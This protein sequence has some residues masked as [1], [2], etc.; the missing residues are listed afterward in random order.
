MATI[1][2]TQLCGS[3][4]S[5]RL[6]VIDNDP[7]TRQH[8]TSVLLRTGASVECADAEH[9]A[10]IAVHR[11]YAAI[12]LAA[13]VP[14]P[15]T[16]QLIENLK[17]L[18][19]GTRFVLLGESE[20]TAQLLE[21]E[22]MLCGIV[23]SA[24]ARRDELLEMSA[25][26]FDRSQEQR[27][28]LPTT[29]PTA[30]HEGTVLVLTADAGYAL[31]IQR[32]LEELGYQGHSFNA[33]RDL[34]RAVELGDEGQFALAIVDTGDN[35]LEALDGVRQLSA[36]D[37]R[38]SVVMLYER[39][40]E[41]SEQAL[42][43]GVLE[44]I[45]RSALQAELATAI[46][47]AK[48]RNVAHQALRFRATHDA[49]THL[50]NRDHFVDV[51]K[52][53]LARSQR[54]SAHCGLIYI[55]LD[56]FKPINDRYGHAAGDLVLKTVAANLQKAL[57][58]SQ[59]AA[60]LGGDE[61][62][63]LIEDVHDT[64]VVRAVAQRVLGQLAEPIT[65]PNGEVVHVHGSLGVALSSVPET[66]PSDL[67]EAADTAMFRA[68]DAGGDQYCLA[69][70]SVAMEVE[71]R[72]RLRS[73]LRGAQPSSDLYLMYQPQFDVTNRVIVSFEALLRWRRNDS[74]NVSPATFIPLLEQMGRSVEIGAWVLREATVSAALWGKRHRRPVRMAVNVSPSQLEQPQFAAYVYEVLRAAGLSPRQLEIEVSEATLARNSARIYGT[75]MELSELGA[76]IVLDDFG[77]NYAAL[78]HL[79][80]YPITALKIDRP[81]IQSLHK[82]SSSRAMVAMII[83]LAHQLDI[84]AAAVGVEQL[85]HARYLRERKCDIY[86]GYLFGKPH[87][88]CDTRREAVGELKVPRALREN[89]LTLP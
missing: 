3:E 30:T 27:R 1:Q 85:A 17:H 65:L 6:L 8:V 77:T 43:C 54:Q 9:A 82:D 70:E 28:R 45:D 21:R 84:R 61:F 10:I 66:T 2:H 42:A 67:M 32:Q 55:D 79:K 47:R 26:A 22:G 14:R 46:R 73:E 18:E 60:R 76:S 23:S 62:V 64:S 16:Q 78:N 19:Y 69:A 49:L 59:S 80:R 11:E 71:S 31:R 24:R 51:L 57:R 87:F 83:D 89:P 44:L 53:A 7:V 13:S 52:R 50:Y 25:F 48:L 35:P 86:Q 37:P 4:L 36:A 68:K 20:H 81:F 12:Y 40:C 72:K 56:D 63:V 39:G 38:L 34:L 88:L 41:L 75:L 33:A 15:I 5:T 74:S 58:R 29:P